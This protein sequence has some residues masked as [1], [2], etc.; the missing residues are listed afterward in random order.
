K[1]VWAA[2]GLDPENPPKT[3]EGFIDA[4]KKIKQAGF[5]PYVIG[6]KDGYWADFFSSPMGAQFYDNIS[7]LRSAILGVTSL[8]AAPNNGWWKVVQDMR[9]LKLFNDD[10]MSLSLGEVMDVFAAGNA[11]FT[12]A[13]QPQAVYAASILGAENV[14]VMVPPVPSKTKLAGY[15]AIPTNPLIIPAKAKY[16]EEAGKF[17]EFAVSK[18][19]QMAM[20]QSTGAMPISDLI[21]PSIMKTG[22]DKTTIDIVLKKPTFTYQESIPVAVLE[23][24][25]SI[26]QE[27]VGG[28]I[29]ADEAAAKF[30][31]AAARWRQDYPEEVKNYKNIGK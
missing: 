15:C 8:A 2:S 4:L 28:S 23:S 12:N 17:L 6:M 25:Y 5:T 27:L 16:P 31:K 22:Y 1:K 19:R 24:M 18:E 3:Y 9:D 30:E 14:G 21:D 29:N 13:V 7:Q 10:A 20:Y 26:C 11:G